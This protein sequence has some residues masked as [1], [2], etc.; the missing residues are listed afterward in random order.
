MLT[1][2]A[3]CYTTQRVNAAKRDFAIFGKF[4]KEKRLA[5]GLSQGQL[6]TRLG[7]SNP[8]PLSNCERGLAPFPV[9]KLRKLTKILGIP[10]E[11]LVE[12]LLDQQRAY[13]N[14]HLKMKVRL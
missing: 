11:Q 7:Y 4:V 10:P 5:A 1:R 14:R 13:Y 2:F 9:S 8:Q 6:A 12:V 3:C